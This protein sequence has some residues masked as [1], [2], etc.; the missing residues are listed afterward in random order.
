MGVI[1][2]LVGFWLCLLSVFYVGVCWLV[3]F[4]VV[5]SC[6]GWCWSSGFGG[7]VGVSVWDAGVLVVLIPGVTLGWVL[8]EFASWRLLG[9]VCC[10]IAFRPSSGAVGCGVFWSSRLRDTSGFYVEFRGIV[11]GHSRKFCFY[12]LFGARLRPEFDLVSFPLR[13][14]LGESASIWYTCSR[15]LFFR[16][17]CGV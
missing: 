9:V 2:G 4:L 15:E 6:G 13:N 3:L 5:G 7:T 12:I 17:F 16:L 10:R 1:G 14:S 11:L 8:S